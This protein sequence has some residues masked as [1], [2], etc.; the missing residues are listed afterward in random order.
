[1]GW[2][3]QPTLLTHT[4][5]Q[6][7]VKVVTNHIRALLFFR[8]DSISYHLPMSVSGSVSEWVIDSFRFRD[9]YLISELCELVTEGIN[10]FLNWFPMR[11][12]WLSKPLGR[13]S[14]LPFT[15]AGKSPQ[16][17]GRR[18]ERGGARINMAGPVLGHFWLCS[19]LLAHPTTAHY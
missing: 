11:F 9:S 10:M 6:R 17:P 12:L 19:P 8:C 13:S 7:P 18:L 14:E 1:M 2:D 5:V 16:R 15:C 3:K 4:L